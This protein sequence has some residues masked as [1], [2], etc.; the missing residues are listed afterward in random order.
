MRDFGVSA[1]GHFKTRL[2]EWS[3]FRRSLRQA[4]DLD[5][6]LPGII[7]YLNA[8]DNARLEILLALP[9]ALCAATSRTQPSNRPLNDADV[10]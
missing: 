8:A 5:M 6:Y 2:P 3:T 7:A 9:A 1:L 10:Y 4:P